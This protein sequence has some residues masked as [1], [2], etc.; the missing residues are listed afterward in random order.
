MKS[1]RIVLIG[2]RP[3]PDVLQNPG[4]QL[5]AAG[6]II[7]FASENDYQL[8]VVD[9]LVKSFPPPSFFVKLNN[10]FRRVAIIVRKLTREEIGGIIIF[11]GARHSFFERI[12]IAAIARMFSVK[13]AFCIR[14]GYY[15]GWI[16]S[17]F[18]IN[19][20]VRVLL[21]I[22]DIFIC[23]GSDFKNILL[24][25]GV[26]EEKAIIVHNW[27]P[28]TF[29]IATQVK[30]SEPRENLSLIFVGWLVRDK[31]IWELVNAVSE[32]SVNY[33]I[34]LNIAGGGTLE[35]EL[36]DYVNKKELENIHFHGWLVHSEVTSLL[37]KSDVFVLPTY[38][39]GF[40]NALLEAMARG[41]P[42]ICS[43]VG[44]IP[45]S[46]QEDIN[47]MLIPSKNTKA[48]VNAIEK[49]VLN[50]SLIERHSTATLKEVK[51]VHD[52]DSNL[53]KLFAVFD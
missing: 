9:T 32:L 47:G 33:D 23:Q 13:S 42:A 3:S 48:L 19:K 46:I 18:L 20:L 35:R 5:T 38:V 43:R 37:D 8:D 50:R 7:D 14:D 28:R 1:N 39:E 36:K 15:Q 6:G 45:D 11:A 51:Y 27:M 34:T 30:K 41:L 53:N 25:I 44:A 21:K 12:L 52:F 40:P 26:P 16:N 24:T 10:G 29:N 2:P 22:P 17:S 49:Y 4:G 31:G